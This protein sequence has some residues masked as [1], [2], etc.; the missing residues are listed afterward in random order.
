[1]MGANH[2]VQKLRIL[3]KNDDELTDEGWHKLLDEVIGNVSEIVCQA[4]QHYNDESDCVS[5]E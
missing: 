1:M 3:E 5:G 4:K 2:L